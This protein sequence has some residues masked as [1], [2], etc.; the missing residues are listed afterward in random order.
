MA[1]FGVAVREKP[2]FAVA[3]SVG[4]DQ[5]AV[6]LQLERGVAEP[7]EKAEGVLDAVVGAGQMLAQQLDHQYRAKSPQGPFA[8]AQQGHLP[9][10]DIGLDKIEPVEVERGGDR[11]EGRK[12]DQL[13]GDGGP[14]LLRAPHMREAKA[15]T[16]ACLDRHAQR[17]D[18]ACGTQPHRHHRDI[19]EAVQRHHHAQDRARIAAGLEGINPARRRQRAQTA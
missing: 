13:L 10:F 17:V 4:R 19:F 16:A 2:E 6:E 15:K 7:G 1:G 8:A 5:L 12:P 14:T 9:A 18:A 11:V 3:R